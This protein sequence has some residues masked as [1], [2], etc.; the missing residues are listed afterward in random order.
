M[1][2]D[3]AF[4]RSTSFD[5]GHDVF[6]VMAEVR[7]ILPPVFEGF[8]LGADEYRCRDPLDD[9]TAGQHHWLGCFQRQWIPAI[10]KAQN[11]FDG[12]HQ[13]QGD[14]LVDPAARPLAQPL[15]Q[16]FACHFPFPR[17]TDAQSIKQGK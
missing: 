5:D 2:R 9:D 3:T 15:F 10:G 8:E 14:T 1:F 12:G 6:Q 16:K 7:I 17:L 4:I 11:F 13:V